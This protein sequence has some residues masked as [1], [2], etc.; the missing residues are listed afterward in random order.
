MQQ[1]QL[2]YVLSEEADNE[3]FVEL[4]YLHRENFNQQFNMDTGVKR[5]SWQ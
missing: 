1:V 2:L 3:G 5:T 4:K